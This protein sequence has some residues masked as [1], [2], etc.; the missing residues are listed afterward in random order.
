MGVLPFD[1]PVAAGV[2]AAV[3]DVLVA[4]V[5]AVGV[6]ALDVVEI[7]KDLVVRDAVGPDLLVPQ[8]KVALESGAVGVS[9]H[10]D[11]GHARVVEF[12]LRH[13]SQVG[14]YH[15]LFGEAARLPAPGPD[16]DIDVGVR[17]V[18][19]ILHGLV[20]PI[21]VVAAVVVQPPGSVPVSLL[22]VERAARSPVVPREDVG[23]MREP[24]TAPVRE[25]DQSGHAVRQLA[26][27]RRVPVGD[28]QRCLGLL[29]GGSG[30]SRDVGAAVVDDGPLGQGG[31][32]ECH[33]RG[34]HQQETDEMQSARVDVVHCR[35]LRG[36][37]G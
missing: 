24:E 15:L 31:A 35:L 8:M 4:E 5:C 26:A 23:R 13:R 2:V 22:E 12:Q 17:R 33:H 21:R 27:V 6:V 37:P 34:A 11:E 7:E 30:D 18:V 14:V 16:N 29:D 28:V 1:R 25:R 10:I 9:R 36:G 19:E 3:V 32:R 20:H